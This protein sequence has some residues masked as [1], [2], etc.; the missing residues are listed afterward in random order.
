MIDVHETLM[1]SLVSAGT[2]LYT[3]QALLSHKSAAM[4]QRYAHLS[5][6]ALRDAVKLSD[7]LLTG[8]SHKTQ[9]LNS[10]KQ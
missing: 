10:F 4:T 1:Q 9:E 6:Q 5:D 2:N 7:R 8:S 3:V